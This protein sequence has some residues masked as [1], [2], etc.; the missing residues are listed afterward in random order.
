VQAVTAQQHAGKAPG[1][2]T[3]E[4]RWPAGT[5]ARSDSTRH[6]PRR[7]QET[8]LHHGTAQRGPRV[9]ADG[10]G[11]AG[12]AHRAALWTRTAE[13]RSSPPRAESERGSDAASSARADRASACHPLRRATQANSHARHQA[14]AGSAVALATACSTRTVRRGRPCGHDAGGATASGEASRESRAGAAGGR[15]DASRVGVGAEVLKAAGRARAPSTPRN[16]P[17]RKTAINVT[18]RTKSPSS[19][20]PETG[21]VRGSPRL[22]A[23]LSLPFEGG[24]TVRAWLEPARTRQVEPSSI[25]GDTPPSRPNLPVRGGETS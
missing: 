15:A 21:K 24:E 5:A 1:P 23:R 14:E 9:A 12:R 19:I 4:A 11:E 18:R 16:Q 22:G 10:S 8:S 6:R 17:A 25:P 3:A 2:M 7:S 13:P 20:G